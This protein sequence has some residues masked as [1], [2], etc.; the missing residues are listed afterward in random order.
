MGDA[1]VINPDTFFDRL[2][3]LHTAWK[4]DKKAGDA[5]FGGA[6]SIVILT[7]K[8]EQES[9]YLKNQAFHVSYLERR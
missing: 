2:G 3:H 7:G 8:A 9:S 1:I 6:D 5:L 4:A